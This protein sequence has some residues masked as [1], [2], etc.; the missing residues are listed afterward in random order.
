M[1]SFHNLLNEPWVEQYFGFPYRIGISI[2]LILGTAFFYYLLIWFQK[3][4]ERSFYPEGHP[5]RKDPDA[6]KER[7]RRA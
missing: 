5:L 7:G 1:S 4:Q 3:W 2:V 6:M